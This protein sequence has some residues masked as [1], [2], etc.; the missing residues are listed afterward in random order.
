MTSS[1][2]HRSSLLLFIF[3]FFYF[4]INY[5]MTLLKNMHR[6]D[7]DCTSETKGSEINFFSVSLLLLLKMHVD[8]AL[9]KHEIKNEREN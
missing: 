9:Q 8:E 5:L 7:D 1:P 3:I 2:V 4:H 6:C